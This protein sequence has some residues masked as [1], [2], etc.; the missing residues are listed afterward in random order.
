V[1]S[2]S[3]QKS[4]INDRSGDKPIRELLVTL[5]S[6]V[7]FQRFC[8]DHLSK[9]RKKRP[10]NSDELGRCLSI[11]VATSMRSMARLLRKIKATQNLAWRPLNQSSRVSLISRIPTATKL[12]RRC[13]S[14][15]AEASQNVRVGAQTSIATILEF[16][17]PEVRAA[18]VPPHARPCTVDDVEFY[19]LKLIQ[20]LCNVTCR[21]LTLWPSDRYGPGWA[22]AGSLG[23]V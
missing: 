14:W 13:L 4:A 18:W 23:D 8:C 11:C 15:S 21:P 5:T 20:H 6:V 16:P 12:V 1:T 19:Y 7:L 9:M 3:N 22:R 17:T 10:Y 2:P